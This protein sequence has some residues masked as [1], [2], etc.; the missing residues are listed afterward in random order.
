MAVAKNAME[1]FKVLD[2]SNCRE[3]GEKTCLAF[4]AAVFC[5]T[6]RI[7]ECPRLDGMI[8]A[9]FAEAHAD[10]SFG[11]DNE[12][13]GS[14]EQMKKQ[15]AEMDYGVIAKRI[16][17]VVSG[18]TLQVRML[19]KLFGIRKNGTFTTDL[20]LIPWVVVPLLDY[21]LHCQG[22]PVTGEWLSY[23][24]LPGGKEKYASF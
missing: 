4:A 22:E 13:E 3:C 9:R 8:V 18:D 17:A 19:G 21:V 11:P 10:K 12:L 24:E 2:K 15:I 20:H 5:G 16:G 14:I 7:Q 6:R 23:R 1:I